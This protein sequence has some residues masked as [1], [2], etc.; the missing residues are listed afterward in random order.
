MP[1]GHASSSYSTLYSFGASY[2]GQQPKAGLIDLNGTLYGTTYGGGKYVA[3]TVFSISTTGSEKVLYSF[4][5]Y[6]KHTDGAH[7]SASLIA[8]NGV[9]YGTTEYGGEANLGTVFKLS[10]N[11]IE[12]VLHGFRGYY[13]HEQRYN[14]GANPVASLINV[15]GKLYGTTYSG[16][17]AQFYGTV[18]RI[19][20]SGK[21]KVLYSF[22]SFEVG[23]GANPVASLVDLG[24]T[25]YGTTEDGGQYVYNQLSGGTVFSVSTTGVEK[26]LYA[27]L[28]EPYGSN[29]GIPKAGLI[30]VDGTLFGTTAHDGPY[31]YASGTAFSITTSGFPTNLHSFGS[32]DDGSGSVAPLLKMRGTLYGTT[33]AGGAYGKGTV[34][35]MSLGGKE[36]VLHSFGYG[37]DGATPLAGLIDVN[38]TLYGTT[39][40]GGTYGDGTVFALKP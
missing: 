30:N 1:Q 10:A 19:S 22:Q 31:G 26:V 14:D 6:S 37:S 20:T 8:V 36:K 21:E 40:A 25:L 34:F 23:D 16:G 17:N 32:G 3:G 39:S 33:S 7:P 27:F 29:G 2:N 38:G 9:F 5:T 4:N 15:N 18:F 24:G 28:P 35:K 11:G 13:Y 12:K